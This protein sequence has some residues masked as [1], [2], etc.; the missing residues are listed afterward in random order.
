MKRIWKCFILAVMII[1][2]NAGVCTLTANAAGAKLT[3]P[4]VTLSNVA[5]SGKIKIK[6]EP[7][8]NAVSYKVY[9]SLDGEK[10]TRLITTKGTSITNT[11]AV[12]GKK[13]YYKVKAIASNA[14]YNSS[15]SK[16]K[17][18]TCDLER[19]VI[20]LETKTETGKTIVSWKKV[21]NAVS[22]KLYRSKNNKNWTLMKTTEKNSFTHTSATTGIKYYYKVKAIASKSAANSSFSKIKYRT[23]KAPYEMTEYQKKVVSLANEI[24]TEWK[25]KYVQGKNG[26]K[27]SEG[28][29]Q[30]DCSGFSTYVLNTVMVKKIPVFR[31]TS[32]ISKLYQMETVYNE[33]YPGEFVAKT[34]PFND[35]QPGDVIFFSHYSANDHCGIYIGNNK[36]I[37]STKSNGC[38]A[39]NSISGFYKE[40]LSEI[41]RYL[42]TKVAAANTKKTIG[43]GCSLYS[44]RGNDN[45]KVKYLNVGEKVTVLYTG[46]NPESYNQAYVKTADGTKGFLYAKNLK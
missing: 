18:R 22:Y 5:S 33:G 10:W 38:V 43:K 13:Y 44:K 35:I 24:A 9:R 36:F 41:R 25:T 19:P 12:A 14:A 37:H 46:N 27:N 16:V 23:C 3:A 15:Y 20:T 4:V 45:S 40:D 6:W 21:K 28:V 29:Y 30:F 26:Q 7:V 39:V 32:S 11:S 34:V 1:G 17:Y 31:L 8:D 42:P 2:I